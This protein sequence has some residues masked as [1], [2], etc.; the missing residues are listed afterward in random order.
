MAVER[1]IVSFSV[2]NNTSG[3]YETLLE[4][5]WNTAV[6]GVGAGDWYSINVERVGGSSQK[7]RYIVWLE[8]SS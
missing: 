1:K 5:A 6:S 7:D 2:P 3:T 8:S 4:D